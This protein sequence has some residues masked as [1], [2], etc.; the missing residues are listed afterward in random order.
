MATE[1]MADIPLGNNDVVARTVE[2]VIPENDNKTQEDSRKS[3]DSDTREKKKTIVNVVATEPANNKNSN[4][5]T[6]NFSVLTAD[7]ETQTNNDS[8]NNNAAI[9]STSY[10]DTVKGLDEAFVTVFDDHDCEVQAR[11]QWAREAAVGTTLI[12]VSFLVGGALFFAS[13]TDW[14]TVDVAL[15]TVYTVTSAGYGHV[16]IP[17][18]ALYQIFDTFYILIGLSLMAI[19]MAQVYQ[20]LEL[21]A[22]RLQKHSDKAE[23]LQ[24]GIDRLKNEP[25]SAK[26]DEALVKL[27]KQRNS[28]HG[29]YGKCLLYV[30]RV[31]V[32]SSENPWGDFLYR[33]GCLVGLSM[34]G[35]IPVGIL[36][37]WTWYGSIYWSV[38]V[39]A[40]GIE[41]YYIII[42]TPVS[43]L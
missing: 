18:T 24:E 31:I 5:Q 30:T 20:F 14:A 8:N 19:M 42:I 12:N 25:P 21:E 16:D 39:C 35:A 43:M 34:M 9:V 38:V 7:D 37:G 22:S 41:W 10:G 26:R 28:S 13:Q 23:V 33:I 3:Q 1:S 15:F 40:Y 11:Q 4:N 27:K 29:L 2:K 36:E 17:D 6:R 32:F